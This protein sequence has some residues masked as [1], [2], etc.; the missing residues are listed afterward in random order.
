MAVPPAPGST[1]VAVPADPSPEYTALPTPELPEGWTLSLGSGGGDISDPVVNQPS[2]HSHPDPVADGQEPDPSWKDIAPGATDEGGHSPGYRPP[3]ASVRSAWTE[4]SPGEYQVL[5]PATLEEL[6]GF[7]VMSPP[8]EALDWMTRCVN[9]HAAPPDSSSWPEDERVAHAVLNCTTSAGLMEQSIQRYGADRG[10]VQQAYS[11]DYRADGV[12]GNSWTQ[13]PTIGNPTPLD[14]RPF[15]EKCRD[16]VFRGLEIKGHPKMEKIATESCVLFEA[17]LAALLEVPGITRL[18][19]EHW[20]LNSALNAEAP[21]AV[22]GMHQHVGMNT[23]E[24][25]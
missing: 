4:V 1:P 23:N 20:T 22:P 3:P 19:A 15:A 5:R 6:G 13:C 24:T 14:G 17:N 16:V 11:D 9:Y 7:R 8:P 12:H 18:C 21:G 10:C 2:T 25:C